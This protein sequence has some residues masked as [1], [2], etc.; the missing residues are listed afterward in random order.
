MESDHCEHCDQQ[1]NLRRTIFTL[2]EKVAKLETAQAVAVVTQQHVNQSLGDVKD[3]LTI[4]DGKLDEI[5]IQMNKWLGAI[6]AL[7]AVFGMFFSA[8][9]VLK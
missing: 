6:A 7:V 9:Q 1:E 2:T 4:Q 8:W 5:K 3:H